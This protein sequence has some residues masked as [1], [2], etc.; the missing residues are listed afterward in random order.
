MHTDPIADMLTRIRNSQAIKKT[1]VILPYSRLKMDI[2]NLLSRAGWVGKVEKNEPL[3]AGAGKNK[4][5]LKRDICSKFS[6]IKVQILYEPDGQP[7]ISFLQ[8]V[9]KPSCRIYVGKN[10][11][12]PVRNGLG[13]SII[14][15]S[16]GLL[17]DKEARHQKV[18]GEIMLEVY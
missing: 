15:T 1:E 16:Q 3:E 18:G 9:S 14:S 6:S 7:K 17:T 8:R 13:M 11:I 10:N 5:E 12:L 2:L 4:K